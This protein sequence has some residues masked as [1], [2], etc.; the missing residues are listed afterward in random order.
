LAVVVVLVV[1]VVVG[2]AVLAFGE[3]A[4]AT[5]R[6]V[7][8]VLQLCYC[9]ITVVLLWCQRGGAGG[10]GSLGIWKGI[11]GDLC[12]KERV[13][14]NKQRLWCQRVTVVVVVGEEMRGMKRKRGTYGGVEIIHIVGHHRH[15]TCFKCDARQQ[16]VTVMVLQ[17]TVMVL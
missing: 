3:A 6:G 4:V 12:H 10:R 14:C 1:V 8:F 15:H 2:G 5:C 9:G 11:G 7:T 16:R 13:W 17:V